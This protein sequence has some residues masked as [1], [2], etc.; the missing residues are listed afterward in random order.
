MGLGAL[1]VSSYSCTNARHCRL[2]SH[3]DVRRNRP[4]PAV[5]HPKRVQG[6]ANQRGKFLL[7]EIG[8]T[9]EFAQRSHGV[10]TMPFERGTLKRPPAYQAGDHDRIAA[11]LIER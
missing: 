10:H 9:T 1:R 11:D 4:Q 5:P 6:H 8:G 7:R 2:G 3:E